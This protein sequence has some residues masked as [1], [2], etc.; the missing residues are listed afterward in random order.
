[1]RQL[2]GNRISAAYRMPYIGSCL[3]R[4]DVFETCGGFDETMTLGED[5]D[6]MYRCW[7]KDVVKIHVEEVSLIYR[8]HPGNTSRGKNVR[9]HMMVL[10]RRMERIRSGLIDP[11]QKRRFQF[12]DYIGDIEGASQWTNWSA[13]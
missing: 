11:A 8:R 7:E 1:M 9:S 10:K 6:L 5:H 12:R 2:R 3:F 4:R 13:S